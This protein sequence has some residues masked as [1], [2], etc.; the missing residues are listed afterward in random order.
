MSLVY[1]AWRGKVQRGVMALLL[2]LALP[3]VIASAAETAPVR[4]VLV[5]GD[6]LSAAYGLQ[7]AQGWVALTD[8]RL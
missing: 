2:A 6:S 4:K 1:G 7:P 8:E 5:M 3:A